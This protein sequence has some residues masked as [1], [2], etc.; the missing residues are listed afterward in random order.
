MTDEDITQVTEEIT[1]ILDKLHNSEKPLTREEQRRKKVLSA[2]KQLLRVIKAAREKNDRSME[3]KTGIE[4][5]LV[6]SLGEK[7]PHLLMFLAPI[8]RS[9]FGWTVL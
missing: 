4:Y 2:R 5:T 9:K 7:H 8:V 6:T 1:E 3:I